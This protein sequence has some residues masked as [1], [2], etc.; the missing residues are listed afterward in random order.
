MQMWCPLGQSRLCQ[1]NCYVHGAL[2]GPEYPDTV[3]S[4]LN[5]S[6]IFQP[7]RD[8]SPLDKLHAQPGTQ[9]GFCAFAG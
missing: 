1:R 3:K 7:R 4:C 6:F 5:F 9:N 8:G 2:K